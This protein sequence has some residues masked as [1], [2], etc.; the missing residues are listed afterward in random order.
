MGK[1][2]KIIGKNKWF[3]L[4]ARQKH[5][6]LSHFA[7]DCIN[8]QDLNDFTGTYTKLISWAPL[9][10]YFPPEWI[11]KVEALELYFSFHQKLSGKPVHYFKSQEHT[12]KNII[13][14]P[15]KNISVILDQVLT[16]YNVGSILRI[17]DNFGYSELIHS[18]KGLALDNANLKKSAMGTEQWI[19]V[20]YESNLQ[21]FIKSSDM[22][23]IALEKT[24]SS[25]PI[26]QW[27]PPET[28]FNI[29]IGNE[30]YGVSKSILSCCTESV[31][32]PMNGFKNSMNLSHAFAIIS[33]YI[34]SFSQKK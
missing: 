29:I 16:P 19:P 33:F 4:S 32:I 23:S 1:S 17:I 11:S 14:N 18:T 15:Q 31:H 10:R 2:V 30:A 21:N 27:T 9:D 7:V 25:L 5:T 28:S 12:L 34:S 8:S 3:S 22:P 26:T 24:E 20:K 13:W 6:A